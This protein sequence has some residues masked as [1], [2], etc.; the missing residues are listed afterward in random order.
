MKKQLNARQEA[1]LNSTRATEQHVDENIGLI[2]AIPAF[3]ATYHKIKAKIALILDATQI[4][5]ASLAGIAAGK[6]D[7]RQIVSTK[8]VAIAGLVYTYAV[9]I[10]DPTL[11]EEMKLNQSRLRRTR[12]DELAPLC[13]FVH[14]RAETHLAALDEYNIDARK[15]AALQTAIDDFKAETPKP[16]TAV[17][18]RKTTNVNII[19]AFREL[20]DLFDLFDRQ[21]ESLTEEHPDFVRTYFSTRQI[22]DPPTK[23]KK[24][25]EPS[26]TEEMTQ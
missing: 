18:N 12:D 6:S 9:D 7:L 15:L 26:T 17:S 13:Q 10:H 25:K 24:P 19:E 1:K 4:K 22:L 11:R 3:L 16:R 14:D 2:N 20:D 23:S 21:I 5:S 8:T